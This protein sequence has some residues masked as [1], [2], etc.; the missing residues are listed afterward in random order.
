MS[1]VKD[2][3]GPARPDILDG[4][5]GSAELVVG[6]PGGVGRCGATRPLIL[7]VDDHPELRTYIK[8]I[9][10]DYNF[11]VIEAMDADQARLMVR[12]H[13]PDLIFLDLVLPGTDDGMVLCRE[14]KD[15]ASPAK[16]AVV[17]LVSGRHEVEDVD[18]AY[19]AGADGYLFKPFSPRQVLAVL[20]SYTLHTLDPE[21]GFSHF[22]PYD[23]PRF[24]RSE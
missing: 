2:S 1:K 21:E 6:A 5:S 8:L 12:E 9:I 4:C 22:W 20:D 23:V 16:A 10:D 17:V 19:A 24:Y 11:E 3:G 7:I 15:A 14:F 13:S 18:K